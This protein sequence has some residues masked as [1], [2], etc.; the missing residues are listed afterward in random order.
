MS[1]I[2][3]EKWWEK[4]D[5]VEDAYIEIQEYIDSN[6]QIGQDV[7][8]V[9]AMKS[10]GELSLRYGLS[11]RAYITYT[12]IRRYRI[13]ENGY[14]EE[15]VV[16]QDIEINIHNDITKDNTTPTEYEFKIPYKEN[17]HE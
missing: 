15:T 3:V 16:G 6:P 12:P 5:H 10:I 11:T 7:L 8:F 9:V 17:T 2:L 1:N 4:I 14:H 13:K